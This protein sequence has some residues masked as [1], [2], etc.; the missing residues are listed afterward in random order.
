MYALQP[1]ISTDSHGNI[2]M[3]RSSDGSEQWAHYGAVGVPR[4]LVSQLRLQGWTPSGTTL[5]DG[6]VVVRRAMA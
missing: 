1:R 4:A 6:S 3:S 5:S 2:Y